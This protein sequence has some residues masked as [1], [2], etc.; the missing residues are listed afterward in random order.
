MLIP[1]VFNVNKQAPTSA[2]KHKHIYYTDERKIRRWN[3]KSRKCG[4][5]SE[6]WWWRR[7][8][9]SSEK[10]R[11]LNFYDLLATSAI[12]W[13][14]RERKRRLQGQKVEQANTRKRLNKLRRWVSRYYSQV[15]IFHW[16]FRRL[17]V[18]GT[19]GSRSETGKRQTLSLC[20]CYRPLG[21]HVFV[22]AES[23]AE[24]EK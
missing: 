15:E 23:E 20:R 10:F 14:M 11:I 21:L 1:R 6:I 5:W 8:S 2:D 7:W 24:S 3:K 13:W 16:Q 17:A 22:K 18:C 19:S 12:E 9:F 4:W